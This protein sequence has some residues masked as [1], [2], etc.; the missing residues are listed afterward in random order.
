MA[1]RWTITV[2]HGPRVERA[3]FESLEASIDAVEKR[4]LELAPDL[5]SEAIHVLGRKFDPTRQVVARAEVSGPQGRWSGLHGGVDLRGD[6]SA[7]AYTGR[8]RRSV[9]PPQT[10]ESA[11]D[12]LRRALER[13]R[14]S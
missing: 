1:E 3:H 9:V 5:R 7:E 4:V 6:G 8:L 11:Y 10:G 12:A 14:G 2:R 13:A